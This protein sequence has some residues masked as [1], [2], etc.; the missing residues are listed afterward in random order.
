MFVIRFLEKNDLMNISLTPELEKFIQKKVNS[1][2]YTSASEVVRESLRLLYTYEDLQK[3]RIK[4]LNQE[5]DLGLQQLE[6]GQG[7][8]AKEVYQRLRKKITK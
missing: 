3:N 5:I 2:L 6:K 8:N 1:G 4:Q 7:K